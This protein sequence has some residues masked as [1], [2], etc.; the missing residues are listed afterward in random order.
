[1]SK[2]NAAV[3]MQTKVLTADE[4]ARAVALLQSGGLVAFPTETVYGLGADATSDA[5][6][7]RIFE[8][9][10]RP[11]FNPLIVHLADAAMIPRIAE[12]PEAARKLATLWPGPLTLVLPLR[13][14]S[15]LSPLVTAGLQTVAVRIPA[16]PLA[17]KLLAGFGG[18]VAAPS[19]NPSGRVSATT[20]LHV[21]DGLSGRIAA[22]ID[23]GG[24]AVGLESTII[25]FDGQT[26]V[27]LRAGGV[28]VEEITAITGPLGKA[29][30]AGISAPGQL[31]SHYAPKVGLRINADK[32]RA[33]EGWLGFGPTEHP[34]PGLNLSL[35]GDLVEAAATLFD[36]LRKMDA[37][38][39]R[40][41]F[42]GFAVAPIPRTGLGLAINDRLTRAAAPR[43]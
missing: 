2:Q 41:G 16:Q 9:K 42:A 38:C 24:C 40:H 27:L 6:V 3:A 26:P 37:I 11:A 20:A 43:G 23:G 34:T 33:N 39:L 22:V 31:R 28:P 35:S 15:G 17:H 14:D 10:N 18:P 5:A 7:A 25:G 12:M 19:A 8:A 29:R 4:T 30:G 1:M 36:A 32:P 13:P 21:L